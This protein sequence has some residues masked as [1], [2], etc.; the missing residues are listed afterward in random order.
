MA[1]IDE[2]SVVL[3]WCLLVDWD[4]ADVEDDFGALLIQDFEWALVVFVDLV[5]GLL[6]VVLLDVLEEIGF[7]GVH[8]VVLHLGFWV[9]EG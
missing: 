7:V 6:P 1:Q 8:E 4:C 3:D 9:E 5:W 2:L